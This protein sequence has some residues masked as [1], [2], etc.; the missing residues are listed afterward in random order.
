MFFDGVA[1]AL[2]PSSIKAVHLFILPL[3]II[4]FIVRAGVSVCQVFVGGR[5]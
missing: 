5:V 2:A 3:N 1:P 4:H